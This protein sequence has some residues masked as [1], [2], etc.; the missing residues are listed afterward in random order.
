MLDHF[1]RADHMTLLAAGVAVAIVLMI[2]LRW[3]GQ[4]VAVPNASLAL[5]GDGAFDYGIAGTEAHQPALAR[6]AGR[7]PSQ[8][9]E[10]RVAELVASVAETGQPVAII[11]QVEGAHVGEV[12]AR[13][14]PHFHAVTGGR[15]AS[16]DAVVLNEDGM[17]VVRLDVVWPPRLA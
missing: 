1:L 11:V 16:C 6:I 14:L 4:R 17:L 2:L 8:M 9:G 15:A 12:H 10:E 5:K 3:T 7:R 13:D